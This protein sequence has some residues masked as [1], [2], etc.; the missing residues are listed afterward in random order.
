[1]IG[2]AIA[3]VTTLALIVKIKHEFL[4]ARRSRRL[5]RVWR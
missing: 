1:M 5:A 2:M 4:A 3:V